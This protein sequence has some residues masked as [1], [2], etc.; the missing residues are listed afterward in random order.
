M[1]IFNKRFDPNKFFATLLVYSITTVVI[2]TLVFVANLLPNDMIW[3]G[4][5]L[6][7][8]LTHA[9]RNATKKQK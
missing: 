6:V 8:V 9:Y 7:W 5:I 4:A 1:K 2:Y 3:I